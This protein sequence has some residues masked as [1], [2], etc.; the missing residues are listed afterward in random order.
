MTGEP[1]PKKEGNCAVNI[2]EKGDATTK[3][4]QRE[5]ERGRPRQG[6]RKN[7]EAGLREKRRRR[8]R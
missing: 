4:R 5:I 7:R 3:A 2:S 1:F 6:G 8:K